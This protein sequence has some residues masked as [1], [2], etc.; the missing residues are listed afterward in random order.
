MPDNPNTASP[1]ARSQRPERI[2][3][4]LDEM[5]R[6]LPA[7]PFPRDD[8]NAYI[9]QLE[10]QP[11]PQSDEG[12]HLLQQWYELHASGAFTLSDGQYSIVTATAAALSQA[13]L[14]TPSDEDLAVRIA[15]LARNMR[16]KPYEDLAAAIEP[17][18]VNPAP[19][20]TSGAVEVGLTAMA[21]AI[22]AGSNPHRAYAEAAGSASQSECEAIYHEALKAAHPGNPDLFNPQK[23][24]EYLDALHHAHDVMLAH[25]VDD[26]PFHSGRHKLDIEN[27]INAL[28]AHLRSTPKT[29]AFEDWRLKV[30]RAV[31]EGIV[32]STT[33]GK[34]TMSPDEA[35]QRTHAAQYIQL[36]RKAVESIPF[37]AT[38]PPAADGK[39]RE[40][41]EAAT[42][43]RAYINLKQTVKQFVGA[44][45]GISGDHVGNA[46]EVFR[47]I[48]WWHEQLK[49]RLASTEKTAADELAALAQPASGGGE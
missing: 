17:M 49:N 30:E 3:Q 13:P 48:E 19:V 38:Q 23:A 9:A 46:K 29:E 4:A 21:G 42:W 25:G 14:P 1:V 12:L 27:H 11:K 15:E 41:L 33:P 34:L 35:M 10:A 5:V 36:F 37:P 24:V 6:L 7:T 16:D 26:E 18:L 2:N 28:V 40:A 47:G 31:F 44:S 8:I 43:K 32:V 45:K 20:P 22:R 39:L